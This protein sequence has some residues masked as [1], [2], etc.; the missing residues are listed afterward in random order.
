MS[1]KLILTAIA[2]V[3]MAAVSVNAEVIYSESFSG[4]GVLDGTAPDVGTG[5]W[6]A[7]VDVNK[8]GT[9]DDTGASDAANDDNAFL[10]LTP[11]SGKIYTLSATLTQPAGA[12]W[13][14]IGFTDNA[15]VTDDFWDN[16]PTA[17]VPWMLYRSSGELDTYMG[18]ATSG[19][20]VDEG[21]FSGPLSLSIV[22]NTV[23]AQWT[24]KWFVNG[25]SVRTETFTSNPTGIHYVGFGRDG[26]TLG[27]IDDFITVVTTPLVP[28]LENSGFETPDQGSTGYTN[29]PT[30]VD[31]WT[32][33]QITGVAGLSGPDGPW[34][35][36]TYSTDPLGDQFAYLQKQATISQDLTGFAVGTKYEL[37]FF[38]SYR[39]AKGP[40]NDLA[41]I[42]DDGLATEMTI[43]YN[44]NVANDTWAFRQSD[45]FVAAKTSYTLTFR[46]TN[47]IGD[48]GDRATIIDGVTIAVIDPMLP[49][50]DGGPDWVAWS[51]RSVVIDANV[52]NNTSDPILPLTCDWTVD[53]ASLADGN[54]SVTITQEADPE[55][56]TVLVTKTS[57][58]DNAS[59][60]KLTLA[61]NNTGSGKEP[62]LQTVE[63]DVYDDPC[64]AAEAVGQ[65]SYDPSDL[66]SDCITDL[67]DF[68]ILASRWLNEYL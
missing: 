23:Q 3:A 19:T 65:S 25:T 51:G 57:P 37:S 47:P 35:C 49:D 40:G 21:D 58:T 52:V 62:V 39:L 33:T 42:L 17:T 1:M 50:V 6:L 24:A 22:L 41:V 10:A 30:G 4:T 31:G 2:V 5:T 60:V 54:L 36:S 68:A 64:K 12:S 63:I 32:F 38:E 55:D 28:S 44:S 11:E 14:A 46:T 8:D 16:I 53:A 67:K 9:F 48:G 61:V 18:P 27:T 43:Y 56:V 34:E 59:V 15:V 26:G 13:V 45:Y 29:N 7:S 66:N 20:K